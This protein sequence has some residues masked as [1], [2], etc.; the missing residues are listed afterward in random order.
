[1]KRTQLLTW[2]VLL[3]SMAVLAPAVNGSDAVLSRQ[4]TLEGILERGELRIGLESGYIPFEM[5]DKRSGMRQKSIWRGN[6]RKAGRQVNLM[7]FD[8]DMGIEMAKALGVKP[9]FIDT[10]WPSIIPALNLG[11]F[12]VIFGGMSITAQRQEK[13]DFAKPFMRIG[14]TILLNHRHQDAI[15]S[16]SDLN[17]ARYKV[18][19]KPATTGE[20]AVKEYLPK[21]QDITFDKERDGA[22][23]ALMG[24]VDAFVYDFPF[25]AVFMAMYGKEKLIFL[26]EPFTDEPLAWAIRKNDP[27]FLAFLNTFLKTIKSDGRFDRIYQKWFKNTDWYSHAR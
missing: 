12:D 4:S 26:D 13:V 23:A 7:G 22:T 9:I 14:Q 10:R 18:A 17:D 20:Q 16:Y 5:I 21:C 2:L 8:I 3:V 11:R 24:N 27:Q 15:E 19:S 1:M 25:N 6:M